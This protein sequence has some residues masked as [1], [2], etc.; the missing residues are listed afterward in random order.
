MT[1]HYVKFAVYVAVVRFLNPDM[2]ILVFLNKQFIGRFLGYLRDSVLRQICGCTR[3]YV[4]FQ[5]FT[6]ETPW[7]IYIYRKPIFRT[8]YYEMIL[9]MPVIT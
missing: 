2:K 1:L 6:L 7:D 3:F 5:G 8:L 9:R 4:V